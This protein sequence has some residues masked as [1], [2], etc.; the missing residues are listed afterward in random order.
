MTLFIHVDHCCY[1]FSDIVSQG[2]CENLLLVVYYSLHAIQMCMYGC[3]LEYVLLQDVYFSIG[4]EKVPSPCSV[5]IPPSW[6][7]I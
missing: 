1:V 6:H 7:R 2:W 4:K 5:E 3:S